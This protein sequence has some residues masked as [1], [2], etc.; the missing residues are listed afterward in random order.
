MKKRRKQNAKKQISGPNNLS[1]NADP[2][3]TASPTVYAVTDIRY[4]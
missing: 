2:S 3:D 4:L 1:E